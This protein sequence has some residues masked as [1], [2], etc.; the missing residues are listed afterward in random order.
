LIKLYS[1]QNYQQ[2][3]GHLLKLLIE[4]NSVFSETWIVVPNHSAKQ[5]LQ[6]SLAKSL[7]VCAQ[8]KFIMPLS[9]NWEILKNVVTSNSSI[10]IF[11]NDVLRWQIYQLITDS[12]DFKFLKNDSAL[13]NF[14][15][16]EKISQTLLKYCDERPELINDWDH[17]IFKLKVSQEWQAEIWSKLLSTLKEES[18]VQLLQKFD[19]QTDFKQK[20]EK[21]ILFATEQLT[22]FQKDTVLKLGQHQDIHLLLTNPSPNEYWYDSKP[23]AAI[24]R[25]KLFNSELANLNDMGNPLLANLAYNKMAIFDAFLNQDIEININNLQQLN[26]NDSLLYSV[27]NDLFELIENSKK[28]NDDSIKIH[29]CHNTLREVEII[30]DE[31]LCI[32]DNDKNLNPEDIIVVAPDINEYVFAIKE[33]FNYTPEG[34]SPYVPYHIDRV[35][36]ADNNYISSLMN[37]LHSFSGEM[38][39][40]VIY[41]LLSQAVVLEKFNMTEDDLPRIKTWIIDSNIRNFYSASQKN[42]LN[43]EAKI[44]NTW[45]FGENRWL[46]GFLSGESEDTPYLSTFGDI[47]GQEQLFSECFNFLTLWFKA[48]KVSQKNLS[49]QEWYIFIK[50]LCRDFLYN[51]FDLD[52]EKQISQ[53]L[54]NKFIQQTLDVRAKVPLTIINS[55]VETVITENNFRSEG[56]IGIRFQ[57]WENAFIV[58]A[59]ALI[60]MGLN[61]SEFPMKEIRSDLDI[62]DN[63]SP[64]LNKST[65]QRDKN[66]MLT[67]LTENVET[68]IMTYIGFDPK[69]NDSQPPSV[70]LADLI[71]YLEIKTDNQFK[72]HYHNMHGFNKNYF[73]ENFRSY[74]TQQYELAQS[75]YKKSIPIQEEKYQLNLKH[76]TDIPLTSLTKFFT[77]PLDFFLKNRANINLQI[78]E[79]IIQ[80]TETYFPNGLESW[81]LKNL[82]FK[83]GQSTATKTGLVSDNKSGQSL[84]N[85]Y[86]NELNPI[87][88][89]ALDLDLQAHMIELE[90]LD[91]KLFGNIKID[92]NQQLTSIYPSKVSTK[93]ICKHWI[94]HLCF[95]SD[96]SSYAH[97][98]DKSIKFAPL[99]NSEE[100]LLAILEKWQQSFKQPWLFCPA[101]SIKFT[102]KTFDI[103]TKKD[104]LKQFIETDNSFP[105]EG[106]KYFFNQVQKYDEQIDSNAFILPI[107]NCIEYLNANI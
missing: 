99:K 104:Y 35:Q 77:D 92:K 64:R 54:E 50:N 24:A 105:S 98:Q 44:G 72:V 48:Y 68:L 12:D 41:E 89:L 85:K 86:I 66:L 5:W 87:Q 71:N 83:H 29:S 4:N 47:A 51:D 1:E 67:A 91:F 2:L 53:L 55:I 6:K 94:K 28:S 13:E 107:I 31:I 23:S 46:S 52:F 16:A 93:N 15:L 14:N 102:P 61:D 103:K 75:Y 84:I 39:A 88:V 42:E 49:P 43:Y 96:K 73:S 95:Q 25:D 62:F 18:P 82:I 69:T 32:L 26:K 65:R 63:L 8:I 57:T 37:L 22:S 34:D 45:N 58:D 20:P 97:F 74:N 101:S 27:K 70:L 81:E 10:N 60:I 30:K 38:T 90:L 3:Y 36:L 80:D 40:P 79:D 33:V 9:F 7:G 106:Q 59:K 100:L 56:Q 76:E 17:G 78:Y 11:S 21:I 19:A